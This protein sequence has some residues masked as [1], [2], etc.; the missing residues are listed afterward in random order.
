[1]TKKPLPERDPRAAGA[2]LLLAAATQIR[3]LAWNTE[4]VLAKPLTDA[5]LALPALLRREADRWASND[6]LRP[7]PTE[8]GLFLCHEDGQCAGLLALDGPASNL[9]A[10]DEERC[11]CFDALFTVARAALAETPAPR[12]PSDA[13]AST[14][15][16][17]PRHP[18]VI[19]EDF[20]GSWSY[21]QGHPA[22]PI[23]VIDGTPIAY[24]HID[25]DMFALA[26]TGV[27]ER[28]VHARAT[29]YTWAVIEPATPDAREDDRCIRIGVTP[30]VPGAFP[31]TLHQ[32]RTAQG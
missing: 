7:F 23:R 21:P 15:Q 18:L 14:H 1:M 22:F 25:P 5:L 17:T 20:G 3:H 9:V 30:T 29:H 2:C 28:V 6:D 24:G 8:A 26:A 13:P 10:P 31:V 16:D 4:V 12:K 19:A 32:E 11:G 27:L